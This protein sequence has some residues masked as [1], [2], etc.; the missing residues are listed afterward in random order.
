MNSVSFYLSRR[1][2]LAAPRLSQ[3]SLSFTTFYP[4]NCYLWIIPLL[5]VFQWFT[6][7]IITNVQGIS[8]SPLHRII[9]FII[10][11]GISS[12]DHYGLL[13]SSESCHCKMTFSASCCTSST[14]IVFDS[15][16]SYTEVWITNISW[17]YLR[18]N[19]LLSLSH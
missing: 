13:V 18:W 9:G 3:Y 17:F 4:S 15:L 16:F 10:L 14:F 12:F 2:R 7:I 5:L 11:S 8:F 1:L 6:G 19:L